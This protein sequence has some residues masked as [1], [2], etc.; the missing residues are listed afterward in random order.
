VF[1]FSVRLHFFTSY[2]NTSYGTR[3]YYIKISININ[4]AIKVVPLQEDDVPG[5]VECIQEGFADDPYFQWVFDASKVCITCVTV[6]LR[7]NIYMHFISRRSRFTQLD[8][9]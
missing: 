8:Q 6:F 9:R 5:V 3:Q 1:G 7:I 2:Y 4:M